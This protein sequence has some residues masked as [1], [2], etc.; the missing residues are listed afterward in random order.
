MKHDF[1]Q[2]K[3]LKQQYTVCYNRNKNKETIICFESTLR[4]LVLTKLKPYKKLGQMG[5]KIDLYT[6][7]LNLNFSFFF[8]NI[9]L[10]FF[11]N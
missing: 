7:I 8:G 6:N 9:I 10:N 4:I 3:V 5:L 2:E 1:S 11:N